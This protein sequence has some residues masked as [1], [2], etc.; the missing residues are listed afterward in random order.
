M[1]TN[2]NY[3]LQRRNL[4]T[5]TIVEANKIKNYSE[6]LILLE[7]L[8]VEPPPIEDVEMYFIKEEI[9]N[10]KTQTKTE[11]NK[12][13]NAGRK[14]TTRSK[15]SNKSRNVSKKVNAKDTAD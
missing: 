7:G 15:T 11:Q 3:F 1:K 9:K 5:K 13:R 8:K 12:T 6:L 2:Y 10:A 4:T 14:K